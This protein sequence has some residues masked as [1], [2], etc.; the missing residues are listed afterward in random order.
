MSEDNISINL[1]GIG[2]G[3]KKVSRV[4]DLFRDKK[5]LKV[6]VIILF[7]TLLIGSSWMRFQNLSLLKDSTT[8]EYI[9]LALDPYYFLRIAETMISEGGLPDADLMRYPSQGIEFTNEILPFA[10]VS[11]FKIVQIFDSEVS[12]QFIHVISP[13]LFF[14]IGLIVFFFLTYTLT[15][16][17]LTALISSAFLAFIPSYLYRTLS[18]FADHESIGM[19]AFFLALLFYTIGLKFLDKNRGKNSSLKAIGAGLVV[20]FLS[21]FSIASWIGIGNFIFMIV[22]L[23]FGIFWIIKVQNLEG[24]EKNYL[25]N[26]LIFYLVWFFSIILFSLPYGFSSS[27]I[28][29][30]FIY[31]SIGLISL[32]VMGMIL[33]DFLAI[34]SIDRGLIKNKNVKKFRILYSIAAIL[35][36]GSILLTL[37]GKN[38][39]SL[40]SEVIDKLISVF[41]SSRT[42]LTVAENRQPFLNEWIAQIGKMF[43]W[44]FYAG[45][46]FVGIEIS[47]GI[48]KRKN[49]ILFSLLWIAMITGILF[50]RMSSSS[51]LNGTNFISKLVYFSGLTLFLLF[52]VWVYFKDKFRIKRELIIISAWLF[53]ML[54][55]GRGAIRFFFLITPFVCFMGGYSISKLV[56]YSK[57]SRDDLTKMILGIL[58]IL[59]I[60]AASISLYNFSA[61]TKFQAE[62]T[63]P[64]A[65]IHWQRAMSWV[66]ENTAENSIFVHWWDY[67][68]WVQYLGERPTVTDGGHAVTY[69][70]HLIGRYLLTTPEPESALSFM[71]THDVSYLLIDPTDLGKYSAYSKIG[72][73][74]EGE[75]RFSQIPIMILDPNQI[76]ETSDKEI[77]IYQGGALVDQD[78]IYEENGSQIFLPANK[79]V[80]I[81]LILESSQT[82]DTLSFGQPMGAFIYNNQQVRIPLRY[83]YFNSEIV[84]FGSGLEATARVITK[85]SFSDQGFGVDKLGSVAYLSPKV[86]NGLFAQLYLLDDAFNR[87]PTLRVA[88]SEQSPLIA[89]LNS[90]GANLDEIIYYQG[91]RGPIKIWEVTY[92]DNVLEKEEFLK[93]KGDYAELDNL[94]FTK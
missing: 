19:F 77:R 59:A 66:R 78:I 79:A 55:S 60:I 46:V 25:L 90:Q 71:K 72:S 54:I 73:G 53:F 5:A 39:F 64:S 92:P 26:L 30:Q 42:A 2:K 47:K 52:S 51:L 86:M 18:G 44:L 28:F 17:K 70:D 38:V 93:T 21:T 85:A 9:P 88:H 84:D 41:G 45:M 8:G 87:Y 29:N 65:N 6:I 16:S 27:F 23:S 83:L 74:P 20:G 94:E 32:F 67:G 15:K 58:L 10:V 49:K 4:Q 3:L 14:I 36:L 12:L 1:K 57:R 50:S 80:I 68:Y 75:D 33:I 31:S 34:I 43:F 91:F 82:G 69:W 24:L 37:S 63:G 11:I 7:L 22:P 56:E 61:S 81:G 35:V 76:Q 40:I 48:G 13:V 89:D 62:N